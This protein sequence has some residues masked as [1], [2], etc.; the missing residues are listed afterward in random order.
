[1]ENG[2][3]ALKIAFGMMIF[4]LAISITISS[5]TQATQAMQRIWDM[6][7]E[8]EAFVTDA[9]GNYLNYVNFNGGTRIVSAETIIP[10]MYRAYK[11]NFEIRFLQA[12]GNQFELYVKNVNGTI[13]SIN[14]I[15]LVKEGYAN[16]AEA[17]AHLDSILDNNLY[18]ELADKKFTEYLGEYY[19]EDVAGKTE[20]ADINK[21]KKRV[22]VYVQN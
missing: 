3:E 21:T 7:Q 11:E 16:E 12:N 14:Y 1:M 2:V 4:V 17:I 19:M 18:E 15:D 5:F 6:Q 20:T 10:N 13:Q 22:I 8:D 9:N